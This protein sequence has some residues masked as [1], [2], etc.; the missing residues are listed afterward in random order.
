MFVYEKTIFY[1]TIYESEVS[2]LTAGW[3]GLNSFKHLKCV[4]QQAALRW[5]NYFTTSFLF[6]LF[7]L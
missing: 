3:M 7:H 1:K 4:L 5:S 6:S 2:T